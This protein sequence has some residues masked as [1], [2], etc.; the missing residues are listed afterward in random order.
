M[1]TD[2]RDCFVVAYVHSPTD[3]DGHNVTVFFSSDERAWELEPIW[4][5]ESPSDLWENDE[6]FFR[7]V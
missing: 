5:A 6:R 4:W 2:Q 3:D 1:F 7:L